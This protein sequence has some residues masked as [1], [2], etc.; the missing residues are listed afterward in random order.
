MSPARRLFAQILTI[1]LALAGAV[2]LLVGV[3]W[4]LAADEAIAAAELAR[5]AAG[6][7]AGTAPG[8]GAVG[9]GH[10]VFADLAIALFVVVP[11][12]AYLG[13]ARGFALERRYPQALLALL[14]ITLLAVLG[15][16]VLWTLLSRLL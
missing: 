9:T 4:I 13:L 2:L 15:G 16:P 1:G 8:D 14:Q 7:G 5:W 11:V 6:R 3:T 12:F 10:T